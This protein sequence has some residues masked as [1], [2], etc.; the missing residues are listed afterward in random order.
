MKLLKKVINFKKRVFMINAELEVNTDDVWNIYNLLAEG[1]I[2]QGKVKRRVIKEGAGLTKTSMVTFTCTLKIVSFHYDGH[3]DS[4]RIKGINVRENQNI[5]LGQH[6]SMDITPPCK[7][8]ITKGEF[9]RLH[10]RRLH[11]V[12]NETDSGNLVA[13]TMDDGLGNIF[14]ISSHKTMHKGKIQKAITKSRGAA[15]QKKHADSQTKFYDKVIAQLELHFSGDNY[16]LFQ[17]VN[18]VAIGSPGFTREN[19]YSH[20]KELATKK[21]SSFLKELLAKIVLSHCSDGHKH[22]LQ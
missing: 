13:I 11:Q 19:F 1:D 7:V 17:K 10:V 21:Q 2:V 6:Q 20:L 9:D 12:L 5:A 22:S 3:N 18:C 4:I 14:L 16:P 15:S 8:M